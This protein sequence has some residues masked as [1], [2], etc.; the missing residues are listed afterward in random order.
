MPATTSKN[1]SIE[2]LLGRGRG[3]PAE[4]HGQGVFAK[5]MLH[6]P[7]PDFVDRIV[8]P[9]IARRRCCGISSRS[10]ITA[11]WPAPDTSRFCRSIRGSSTRPGRAS[12]QIPIY[13][14]PENIVKLAIEGGC[15]AV[16]STLGVLGAVLAKVRP[17][18]SRS[19]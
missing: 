5:E 7:G 17:Q 1:P 16:A 4:L 9:A 2:E 11:G 18:D 12:R 13:F 19:S 8:P 3:Q 10:S 6:L 14:D 15:N